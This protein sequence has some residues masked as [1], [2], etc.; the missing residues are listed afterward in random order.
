MADFNQAATSPTSESIGLLL[1]PPT[2]LSET[3]TSGESAIEKFIEVHPTV[4]YQ[5]ASTG[6][7]FESLNFGG[8]GGA[9]PVTVPTTGLIWPIALE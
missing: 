1:R 6:P 4:S 5:Q 9:P 8:D 3:V 7:V 2:P